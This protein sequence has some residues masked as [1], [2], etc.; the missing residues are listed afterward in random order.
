MKRLTLPSLLAAFA[1]MLLS[2]IAAPAQSQDPL[3]GTW[4]LSGAAGGSAFIA[5]MTFNAGGTTVE[6]DTAGTNSSASP[7]ESISLGKWGKTGSSA[8][9]FKEE[10]YDYDSSGDLA[11]LTVTS[12]ALTLASNQKSFTDQC[13]VSFYTC[14]VTSCPGTLISSTSATATGR[15]F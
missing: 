8:Y 1:V 2:S 6:Y 14:S 12:C 11:S 3:I 4:N 13:T 10:N 15:R 9:M 7:G 5:V